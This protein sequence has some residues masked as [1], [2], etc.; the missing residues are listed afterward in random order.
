M[1][2]AAPSEGET[3]G[4]ERLSDELLV[5]LAALD[6]DERALVVMR[7]LLGYRASELARMLDLPP[8]TLRTRLARALERLRRDLEQEG[9]R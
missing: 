6:G 1:E 7:Y 9:G 3:R 2:V 4:S 8:A 5:A